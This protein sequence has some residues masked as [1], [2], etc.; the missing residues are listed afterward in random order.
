MKNVIEIN[1][2]INATD[3]KLYI[4]EDN[5]SGAEY[6]Y[7][8][9][10]K[11]INSIKEYIETYH[12]EEI[13]K[14]GKLMSIKEDAEFIYQFLKFQNDTEWIDLEKLKILQDKKYVL[15]GDGPLDLQKK[16]DRLLEILWEA[17]EDVPF[18]EIEGVEVLDDDYLDFEFET[19]TKEDIWHWFD[20]RYSKGVHYLLYEFEREDDKTEDEE[21]EDEEL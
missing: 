2:E 4:G 13:Q 16:L 21:I 14:S 7:D 1:I 11:M 8:N 19:T 5:S 20:E 10:D 18:C 17:L 15:P 3:K 9:Y 6:K 12:K